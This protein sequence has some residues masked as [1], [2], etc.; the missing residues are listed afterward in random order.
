MPWAY[1][2]QNEALGALQLKILNEHVYLSVFQK[3][4]L[5][6]FFWFRCRVTDIFKLRN[7]DANDTLGHIPMEH[8]LPPCPPIKILRRKKLQCCRAVFQFN[9]PSV[10]H[11]LGQSKALTERTQASFPRR[12]VLLRYGIRPRPSRSRLA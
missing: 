10:I 3:S 12:L 11:G 5:E 1:C 9:L 6:F 2:A 8:E 4:L 7:G